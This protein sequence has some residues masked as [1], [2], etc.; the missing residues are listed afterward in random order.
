MRH[1]EMNRYKTN[2]IYNNIY[3][4]K[5]KR[6]S[7]VRHARLSRLSLVGEASVFSSSC[8]IDRRD[9]DVTQRPEARSRHPRGDD[10]NGDP[11][12]RERLTGRRRTGA[13][14]RPPERTRDTH[15]WESSGRER[16]AHASTGENPYHE[17]ARPSSALSRRRTCRGSVRG[18]EA[19]ARCRASPSLFSSG[20]RRRYRG[21]ASVISGSVSRRPDASTVSR[22]AAPVRPTVR[23]IV[24]GVTV[25]GCSY[26][27]TCAYA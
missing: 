15:C 1:V 8:E 19:S 17:R 16:I 20:S 9:G 2:V 13:R 12:V 26:V 25:N 23:V 5:I 21:G 10:A 14:S 18:G 24:N 27:R 4:R 7:R 11:S 3:I 22:F 6:D